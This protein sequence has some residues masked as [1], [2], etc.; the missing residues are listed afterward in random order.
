M[1]VVV[2]M[3]IG[4]AHDGIGGTGDSE[5]RTR[6][7]WADQQGGCSVWAAWWHLLTK[8]TAHSYRFNASQQR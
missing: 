4:G 2:S 7:G 8:H 5:P 3:I 1:Y 6:A